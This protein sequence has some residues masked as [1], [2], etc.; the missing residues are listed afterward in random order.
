MTDIDHERT[1][2]RGEQIFQIALRMEI[3]PATS[4]KGG[5][6]ALLYLADAIA[7]AAALCR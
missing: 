5:A 3:G 6:E 1:A 7:R 4:G 2:R